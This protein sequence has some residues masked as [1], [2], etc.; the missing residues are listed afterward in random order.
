MASKFRF[1]A[2]LKRRALFAAPIIAATMTSGCYVET[3]GGNATTYPD[4]A[5]PQKVERKK[6]RPIVTRL[7]MPSNASDVSFRKEDSTCWEGLIPPQQATASNPTQVQC[8]PQAQNR[9]VIKD[10]SGICRIHFKVTTPPRPGIIVNPPRP[11]QVECPPA[12]AV[13]NPPPRKKPR[14]A[15]KVVQRKDGTCWEVISVN[16]PKPVE[17][18]PVRTCNPPPPRQVPCTGVE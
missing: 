7:P 15:P 14:P 13:Q 2:R 5:S 10:E 16:C 8:V 6:P 18:R 11:M 3:A 1:S 17:G 9:V 4:K 12:V